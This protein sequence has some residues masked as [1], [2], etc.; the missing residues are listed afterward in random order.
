MTVRVSPEAKAFYSKFHKDGAGAALDQI[1]TD[2]FGVKIKQEVKAPAPAKAPAKAKAAQKPAVKA[3]TPGKPVTKENAAKVVA[4]AAKSVGIGTRAVAPLAA[5][6]AN[7]APILRPGQ[8][9][10][11]R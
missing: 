9:A 7:A 4:A 1:A 5:M 3:A 6:R 2:K 10:K 8:A 11:K